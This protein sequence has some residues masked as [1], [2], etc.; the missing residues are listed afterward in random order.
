MASTSTLSARSQSIAQSQSLPQE[1]AAPVVLLGRV[2]FSLIFVMGGANLFASQTIAYA[3]SQG[4]PLASVAVPLAG[5]IAVAG[6]LSILLGYK[7]K[8]GAWLVVLFLAGVTP[9]MHQ[10][11][12][13]TDPMMYQIQF[14]MFLKNLSMLGG[15]LLFS[16][17]GAGPWSLDARRK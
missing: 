2:L 9:M 1:V 10:F 7:A 8:I 13:V 12:A 4:V 3:A 6:G 15:A 5:V 11:W 17:F 14:V 16:Q